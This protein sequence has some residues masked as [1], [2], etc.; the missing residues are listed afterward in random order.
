MAEGT[1]EFHFE[2]HI[3]KYLTKIARPEFP[4]YTEKENSC[5]DKDLCLIPEDV[6]GFIK[7]TQPRKFEA[8]S[9]QYG[10]ATET[11]I[12]E[13]VAD[14]VKRRKTLD[15]FREKVRDRGQILDLI[16]FK[17]AHNKTPE[18]RAGY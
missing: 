12:L 10:T 13:R 4:E 3:V 14:E 17:P 16:Y 2:E 15:V 8:L 7:D 5:Y 11:K 18:H 6:I 1:K 9:V